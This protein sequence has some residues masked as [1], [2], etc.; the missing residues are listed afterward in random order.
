MRSAKE[1][2]AFYESYLLPS[3]ALKKLEERRLFVINKKRMLIKISA[4]ILL[5]HTSLL[6]FNLLQWWT[7]LL[8]II[9]LPFVMYYVYNTKFKDPF[10]KRDYKKLVVA[11]IV[12]FINP[13]LEYKPSEAI[14]YYKFKESGLFMLEPDS[15]VGDDY[16]NGEI[17]GE[18]MEM[19][20]LNVS[21]QIQEEGKQEKKTWETLF[22]GLFFIIQRKEEFKGNT[23]L[24]PDESFRR[25]GHLGRFIQNNN[26]F[27]GKK[28]QRFVINIVLFIVL[29]GKGSGFIKFESGEYMPHVPLGVWKKTGVKHILNRRGCYTF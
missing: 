4:W 16:L 2:K 10:I 15:Y 5:I 6:L 18:M 28:V 8:T 9:I 25:M 3:K 27:R 13:C 19:S 21:Y 29:H 23:I 14:P 17:A 12:E 7:I 1:F 24:I 26:P 22:K 11:P 20:E